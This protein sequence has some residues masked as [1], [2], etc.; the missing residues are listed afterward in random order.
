MR[1]ILASQSPRRRALLKG[2]G[3][4]FTVSAPEVDES[5]YEGLH[6]RELVKILSLIK[7]EAVAAG[8]EDIVIAADTV[9]VED[10]VI[11]GK[12]KNEAQA[13]E[14]LTALSGRQHEVFTGVTVKQNGRSVTE[15]ETTMVAFRTLTPEEIRRY[16]RT[17][18]PMDKAGAY[19]IQGYGAM[20]VEGIRGDYPNVVG[21]PVQR[22][23]RMLRGFGV[24]CLALAAG[25]GSA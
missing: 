15:M 1:I 19:G 8:P 2:M 10:G 11:L 9:V 24:D 12:P 18:E 14:M 21:L 13:V 16:V 5:A 6:V 3:L 20:L 23:Y 7:A 25:K 4:E 17:G 22:L